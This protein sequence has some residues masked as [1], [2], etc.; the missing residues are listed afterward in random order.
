VIFIALNIPDIL[1]MKNNTYR[2]STEEIAEELKLQIK[3]PQ[4]QIKKKRKWNFDNFMPKTNEKNMG[5]EI[6]EKSIF[7]KCKL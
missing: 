7:G 3:E 4:I 1:G 6:N 5:M 2:K